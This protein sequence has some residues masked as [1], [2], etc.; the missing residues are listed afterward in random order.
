MLIYWQYLIIQACSSSTEV[1]QVR[2]QMSIHYLLI[3]N[4][5]LKHN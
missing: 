2:L 5:N 4:I 1:H 3:I